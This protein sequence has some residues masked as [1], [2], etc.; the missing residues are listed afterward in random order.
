V[1][2]L[3]FY[4]PELALIGAVLAVIAY[5]LVVKDMRAK[6]LG[7]I[8]ISVLGLAVSA[9][10]SILFL[11]YEPKN[12]FGG[13]LAFD[14]FTHTFRILFALVTGLIVLFAA[15][16]MLNEH[17]GEGSGERRNPAEMLCLLLVI[18]LG[19]NMMASSRSLLM[20]YLSLEMV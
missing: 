12:L 5:D 10:Y 19:L 17:A 7:A 4:V 13:L 9:G 3:P 11:G 6:V 8:G 18:T 2:S 14:D 16:A 1:A 20:I 15:P